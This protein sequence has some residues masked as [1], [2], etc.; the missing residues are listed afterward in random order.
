MYSNNAHE[1]AC[2]SKYETQNLKLFEL[3]LLRIF[4]I[5]EYCQ[6]L[7]DCKCEAM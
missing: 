5:I 4:Y 7:L 6:H 2:G 1:S 3:H